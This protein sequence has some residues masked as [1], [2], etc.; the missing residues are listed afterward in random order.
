M[1][2]EFR[3]IS[4]SYSG[5][6]GNR[7]LAGHSENTKRVATLRTHLANAR[8]SSFRGVPPGSVL[9]RHGARS[10]GAWTAHQGA[11]S[12]FTGGQSQPLP[13]GGRVCVAAADFVASAISV[14]SAG[15]WRFDH[16]KAVRA[17]EHR[18]L[19]R[20]PVRIGRCAARH[21][22]APVKRSTI[23]PASAANSAAQGIGSALQPKRTQSGSR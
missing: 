1:V 14:G 19:R 18:R 22:F 7:T 11:V 4:D 3:M 23:C 6:A 12:A 2:T 5:G 8:R 21:G 20:E 16:R 17:R 13:V 15:S 9:F 10:R